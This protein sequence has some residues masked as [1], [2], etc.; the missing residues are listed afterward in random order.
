M[1]SS[2]AICRR[3]NERFPFRLRFEK[4]GKEDSGKTVIC[5]GTI[6]GLIY[7]CSARLGR[8]QKRRSV[9]R[10]QNHQVF[11]MDETFCLTQEAI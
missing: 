5:T 10:S 6:L 9:E 4:S 1:E 11:R 7:A 2:A 3:A 8:K